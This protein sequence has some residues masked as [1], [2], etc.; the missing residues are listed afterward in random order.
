MTDLNPHQ[1]Y[2]V[3]ALARLGLWQ[4]ASFYG[5]NFEN[6][7]QVYMYDYELR[8]SCVV[9]NEPWTNLLWTFE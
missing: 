3:R 4:H 9:Q 8:Y 6:D 1:F 7:L 5:A 2:T